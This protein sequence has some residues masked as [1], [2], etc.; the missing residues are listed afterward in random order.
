MGQV[1]EPLGG[2]V[3]VNGDGVLDF[4]LVCDTKTVTDKVA[5]S[6]VAFSIFN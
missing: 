4:Y 3:V 6:D 1:V 2:V 5:N